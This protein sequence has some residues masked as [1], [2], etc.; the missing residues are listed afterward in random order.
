MFE[1]TKDD[2]NLVLELVNVALGKKRSKLKKVT[3]KNHDVFLIEHKGKPIEILWVRNCADPVFTFWSMLKHDMLTPN[4]NVIFTDVNTTA[5][6]W[7]DLEAYEGC[8]FGS[9]YVLTFDAGTNV[10]IKP[11]QRGLFNK[12]K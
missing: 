5:P 4:A 7:R 2:V 12:E 3:D 1:G 11:S 9:I 6:S 10:G 8:M